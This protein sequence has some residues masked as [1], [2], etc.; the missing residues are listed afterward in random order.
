LNWEQPYVLSRS[1]TLQISPAGELIGTGSFSRIPQE[2]GF[3][4]IP[5][6]QSFASPITPAAALAKLQERFELEESGFREVVEGL[7]A[8]NFLTPASAEEQAP[9]LASGGFASVLAHH[10]MLRDAYR[11][12]SYK[13]A[14]D[15]T[16]AGKNIVEIGCGSGILSMFAA[17][18]GART[19]TAVEESSIAELAREMFAANHCTIDLRLGNSRDVAL[20]Q[21][22][23]VVIHEIIGFDPLNENVLPYIVD[24]RERLLR[25]GGRLLPHRLEVLCVG[26]EVT[27]REPNKVERSIVE[28]QQFSDR[29]GLDFQ[30]FLRWLAAVDRRK[31]TPPIDA[32][33]G[34]KLKRRILT[35]ECV[36]LDIDFYE[37]SAGELDGIHTKELKIRESGV[38]GAVIVYFRAHLDETT[39]LCNDPLIPATSWGHDVRALSKLL[40][41]RE[42]DAVP[43][44]LTVQP[45]LGKQTVT[46]DLQ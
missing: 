29:Y 10:D 39:I 20:D 12:L 19:V 11:V 40:P 28:A 16:V 43:I 5:V 27:D 17:K 35:D 3:D 15:A 13:T 14:I 41:V 37:A 30:P 32:Y 6:M 7:V 45:V 25:K 42:G 33:D 26:I 31:F 21:P 9:A 4:A 2:V 36:L 34:D 23:D 24:A 18:A 44:R 1:F 22:A 38:L 46:V 8:Q